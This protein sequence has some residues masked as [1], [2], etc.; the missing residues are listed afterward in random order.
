MVSQFLMSHAEKQFK[1]PLLIQAALGEAP[2]AR[3]VAKF[4][5]NKGRG[6]LVEDNIDD[7]SVY[8][9]EF[10]N[11]SFNMKEFESF[12]WEECGCQWAHDNSFTT[13]SCS[14]LFKC[15]KN[16]LKLIADGKDIWDST[17]EMKEHR[18]LAL[19][20][21]LARALNNHISECM[22]KRWNYCTMTGQQEKQQT[23]YA[24]A[25]NN[26]LTEEKRCNGLLHLR[27]CLMAVEPS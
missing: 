17:D 5:M 11:A 21:V 24:I 20:F 16:T 25:G 14:D 8:C 23:I 27:K 19:K 2:I 9:S 6:S 26:F 4:L 13:F 15:F 1:N 22:V 12:I 3:V 18:L 7:H 10:Q